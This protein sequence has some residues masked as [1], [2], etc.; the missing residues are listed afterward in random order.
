MSRKYYPW[1]VEKGQ[2]VETP[3]GEGV[4]DVVYNNADMW[5]ETLSQEVVV[6]LADGGTTR[7]F[8]AW[9]RVDEREWSEPEEPEEE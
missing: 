6:A 2:T 9:K 8:Y 4:V 5:N 3:Y 1:T 7:Q